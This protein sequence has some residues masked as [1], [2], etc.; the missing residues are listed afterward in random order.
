MFF[1]ENKEDSSIDDKMQTGFSKFMECL[2]SYLDLFEHLI[3]Y[4][5]SQVKIYGSVTLENG[6]IMRA[7]S[8]YHSK[9]WFSNISI[10]MN[11]E[12][13][14]DYQSDQGVCYGQ[15]IQLFAYS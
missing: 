15:V 9:A 1:N 10:L 2:T 11:P 13:S 4:E 5:E 8:S 12:E 3:I 6:A 14:N 7:T